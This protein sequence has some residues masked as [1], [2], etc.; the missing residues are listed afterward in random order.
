MGDVSSPDDDLTSDPGFGA[1]VRQLTAGQRLF[2]R[3]L[4]HGILGRGGMGIV[5]R[6]FD[7]HLERDV[8]LKFLP[9]MVTFDEQAVADL[10]RETKKSQ[11]LR[12]HHIVQV[13]DF[14]TNKQNACISM[15]FVD[16]PT[17]SEV[18]ARRESRCLEVEDIK[19]WV[20][21]LCEALWYAH[22]R[23]RVIH[24][25]LKPANL[26]VNSKGEL[27]V[28]DFGIARSVSDSM[29]MLTKEQGTS[30]TLAYMSP[31]Q[32][33]GERVNPADDIYA[34]GATIYELLTSRPPFYSGKIDRQIHEKTPPTMA[35]RR[36]ELDIESKV[37]IP[38]VWE[39]VV[40]ACL[41]K[42][43]EE[44]PPSARDVSEQLKSGR[45][46]AA[47]MEPPPP[48]SLPPTVTM[49][50][51]PRMQRPVALTI[52]AA[53]L[54][55]LAGI[56]A[57]VTLRP[58]ANERVDPAPSQTPYAAATAAPQFV[59]SS[60]AAPVAQSSPVP[61]EPDPTAAPTTPP[62]VAAREP[63]AVPSAPITN[64]PSAPVDVSP[65]ES[66]RSA[67]ANEKIANLLQNW[68]N[69]WASEDMSAYG[70]FYA[71]DFSGRTFSAAKGWKIFDR[72]GWMQD[73]S[74]K[75]SRANRI[76]VEIRNLAIEQKNAT[77][78]EL[79]FDQV[80][81]SDQYRDTGKKRML[82]R[83]ESSGNFV[84]VR[85]DFTPEGSAAA[86]SASTP[87]VPAPSGSGEVY[88][89]FVERWRQAWESRDINLYS[90]FYASDF[91]G[92]NTSGNLVT[93]MN[94]TD[95]MADKAAKFRRNSS[96]SIQI[97]DLV[98]KDDTEVTGAKLVSFRQTY[99]TPG[100]SDSGRK[101][102]R[103]GPDSA[104]N[105]KIL[106]EVFVPN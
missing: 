53:G 32:L 64:I 76:S 77:E 89:T 20:D 96:I 44:R 54:I 22:D 35:A 85:E 26:M 60:T 94:R 82:L 71:P 103:I 15:E 55:L 52:A 47:A 21:Q 86:M 92:Q 87:S 95:W 62:T 98:V 81:T 59:V 8:A 90:S 29:S 36:E 68:R 3:Y 24:R 61:R 83:R 57:F 99:R 25:D 31:Q 40:A 102:L 18:K 42:K 91:V 93:K 75:A 7:E 6:A 1:T 100:Y 58:R 84:I 88:K 48:A 73:K 46:S 30:G 72:A 38:Q 66:F 11:E 23:A 51:R 4:L 5:W 41:A 69:A 13:Y 70:L 67:D 14:V 105:L 39:E 37:P 17:L 10:K 27:K 106:V 80:Y 16:G 34:L 63:V 101:T 104:G 33:D 2:D 56:G 79:T 49:A 28:S 19:E 78:I 43:R 45:T 65:N 12:H 50:P 9:E 97:Q 74:E